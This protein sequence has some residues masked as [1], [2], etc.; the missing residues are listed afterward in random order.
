MPSRDELVD[1]IVEEIL[2]AYIARNAINW[3]RT[4]K[5]TRDFTK[6]RMAETLD[7]LFETYPI[8]RGVL[9]SPAVR[10]VL[11]ATGDHDDADQG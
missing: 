3:T 7:A 5:F 1:Q 4:K 11:A 8:V 9:N 2:P 6:S 10:E